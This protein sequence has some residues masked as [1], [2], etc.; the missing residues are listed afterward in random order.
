M[1]ILLSK[2]FYNENYLANI[3]SF[4]VVV[5]KFTIT[6]NADLDPDINVHLGGGNSIMCKKYSRGLYYYDTT[7]M[8]H[9]TI[10]FLLNGIHVL[11]V[12]A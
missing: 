12:C 9:N 6:V 7:N 11:K 8:E 10:F 1:T 4:F 2:V 3:L 5:H